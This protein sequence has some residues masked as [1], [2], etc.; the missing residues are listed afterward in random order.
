MEAAGDSSSSESDDN[1]GGG[2]WAW[3]GWGSACLVLPLAFPGGALPSFSEV[4][5]IAGLRLDLGTLAGV[6]VD[7]ASG[8]SLRWLDLDLGDPAEGLGA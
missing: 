6:S 7:E 1:S 4:V 8:A 2:L 5:V 3:K